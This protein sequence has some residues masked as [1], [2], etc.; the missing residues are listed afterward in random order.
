MFARGNRARFLPSVVGLLLVLLLVGG[1]SAAVWTDKED[2][3]P[4]DVVT[5][6]GDSRDG[7][8]CLP[9]ETVNVDVQGPNDYTATCSA[10]VD[11]SGAWSCQVTL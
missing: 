7:A 8:G 11:S 2:Y 10:L 6:S 5:I 3:S 9:G 4:G 1:T